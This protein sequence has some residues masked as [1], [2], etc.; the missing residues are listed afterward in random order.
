MSLGI[1]YE[2]AD[3]NE[4]PKTIND[5]KSKLKQLFD[6]KEKSRSLEV[7]FLEK[8]LAQLKES[9]KVRKNNKGEIINRR[10]NKLIGKGDYFEW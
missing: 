3:D 1:R 9:L 7:D 5:L 8:E 6:M 10:L 2:H 4:K